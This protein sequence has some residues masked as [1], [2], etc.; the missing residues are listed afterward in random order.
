MGVLPSNMKIS[1]SSLGNKLMYCHLEILFVPSSV[2][3][4]GKKAVIFKTLVA[5]MKSP[6]NLIQFDSPASLG[7]FNCV[8]FL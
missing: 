8:N 2:W 5:Y 6:S 4:Q 1:S 7:Y 3:E